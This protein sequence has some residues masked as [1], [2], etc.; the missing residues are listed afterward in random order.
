MNRILPLLTAAL[1][2]ACNGDD[3]D[4]ET[5]A[6]GTARYADASDSTEPES[7]PDGFDITIEAEGT[8]SFDVSEPQCE[9]DGLTGAFTALYSG[10]AEV[11]DDGVYVASLTTVE[12]ETPSGCELPDLDIGLVTDVVVRGEVQATTQNCDTYCESKARAYGE[13]E[14]EGDP[15]EA[16]CRSTA[17]ADFESSCSTACEDEAQVI[18]AETSLT[19]AALSSLDLQSLT[20][21]ALGTVTA[22]LTFDRIEDGD[23]N[24]VDE[25]P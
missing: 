23:G 7:S 3:A 18:V 16:S 15:D 17:E 1:L 19:A 12:A 6:M 8:G 4:V 24:T 20:G 25:A 22:D 9:A 13:T 11:D 2:V 14:C 5:E 10:E 21:A